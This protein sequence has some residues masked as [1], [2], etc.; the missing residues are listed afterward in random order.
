[1][2]EAG[3]ALLGYTLD[4]FRAMNI[5]DIEVAETPQETDTHIAGIAAGGRDIFEMRVRARDGR[6]VDI[7]IQVTY[8]A[9]D[10]GLLVGSFEDITARKRVEQALRASEA[11]LAAI[12]D[13]TTDMIFSVDAESFGLLTCNLALRNYWLQVR[14]VEVRPGMHLAELYSNEEYVQQWLGFYRRALAEGSFTVVYQPCQQDRALRLSFNVLKR[15]GQVF[16][17][18]VFGRDITG[19]V[20]TM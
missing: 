20:E 19:S 2:N 12:V 1:V 18:S 7:A 4:E 15:E 16:G 14:N 3:C 17:I 10:G 9:Q 6:I 8:L 11:T 13:S 5:R